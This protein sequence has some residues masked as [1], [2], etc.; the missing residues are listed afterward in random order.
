[1]TGCPKLKPRLQSLLLPTASA[2]VA[3]QPELEALNSHKA[4]GVAGSVM[5]RA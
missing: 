2:L 4:L 3:A 1:M 5:S